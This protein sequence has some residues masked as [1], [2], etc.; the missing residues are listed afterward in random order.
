M[1]QR[2]DFRSSGS[3]LGGMG[4]FWTPEDIWQHLGI[5][6]LSQLGWEYSWYLIGIDQLFC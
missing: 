6:W 3:L 4:D 5:F 1:T 2:P